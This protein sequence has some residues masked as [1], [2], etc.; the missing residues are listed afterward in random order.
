MLGRGTKL[1]IALFMLGISTVSV[2]FLPGYET[3]GAWSAI[4]LALFRI[5]QGI[6]REHLAGIVHHEGLQA[7]RL[8]RRQR[9]FGNLHAKARR[10]QHR[11]AEVRPQDIKIGHVR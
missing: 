1:T 2:A 6:G 9:A 10:H 4:L 7:D 11:P 3:I 8:Q 5:G